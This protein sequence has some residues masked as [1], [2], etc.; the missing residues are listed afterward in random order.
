MIHTSR[1]LK[2]LNVSIASE[3]K[4]REMADEIVGDNLVAER[5]A[6]TFSVDKGGEMIRDVPFVYCPNLIAKVA[7]TV[8]HHER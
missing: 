1:W 6:F 8:Q 7:D 5:G 4:Q 3:K 2:G